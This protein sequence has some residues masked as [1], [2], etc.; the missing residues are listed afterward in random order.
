M[1]IDHLKVALLACAVLLCPTTHAKDLH[2]TTVEVPP[3]AGVNK[4]GGHYGVFNDLIAEFERRTP[5]WIRQTYLPFARIERELET[6]AAD[7]AIFIWNESRQSIVERGEIV[8]EFSLG[9]VARKG[10]ALNAYDDLKPLTI[11]VLR[12]L[13]VTPKFDSDGDLKKEHNKDYYQGLRKIVHKRVDAIAGMIPT[14]R[15]SAAQ[16]GIAEH[17]GGHLVLRKAPL[18]LQCSRNSPHLA[19]RA[20]FDRV[21]RDLRADG[22]LDRIFSVHYLH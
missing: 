3:W 4:Q 12:G 20:D 21:I 1:R 7:C 13:S 22:T 5:H 19:L 9:V 11:S 6:G 17:L 15:Y 2:F 16:R 10:V 18:A 14:I 8:Y